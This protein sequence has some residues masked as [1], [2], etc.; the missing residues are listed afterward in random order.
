[1]KVMP[2][3]APFLKRCSGEADFR[4]RSVRASV[5][6]DII[7]DHITVVLPTAAQQRSGIEIDDIVCKDKGEVLL[8]ARAH[9]LVFG[10]EGENVVANDIFPTVVLVKAGAITPVNHVVFEHD[11]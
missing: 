2:A 1:M 8:L 4:S 5:P 10:A 3:L 11:V 9:E 7:V 6:I